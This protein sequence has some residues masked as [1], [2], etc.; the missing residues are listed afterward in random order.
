[1]DASPVKLA[2]IGVMLLIGVI[3]LATAFDGGTPQANTT[4]EVENP[5]SPEA[6]DGT[7]TTT[8]GGKKD[9]TSSEGVHIG[10]YNGT[11]TEGVAGE[12]ARVLEREGGY[13]IDELGNT[14]SPI[15]KSVIY[16][17]KPN[18]QASAEY[19]ADNFYP[20]AAVQAK[21][22]DLQVVV[23]GNET[24]P[25]RSAVVLVMIGADDAG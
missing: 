18:N 10:V 2:V 4:V 9:Q 7:G 11:D 22:E 24:S 21:P 6:T 13:V 15:K 8:G 1:V 19:L 17:S 16:F 3:T 20:G 12:Q 14:V 25:T 23:E 5:P